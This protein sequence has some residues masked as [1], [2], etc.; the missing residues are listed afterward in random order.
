MLSHTGTAAADTRPMVKV[1]TRGAERHASRQWVQKP[2]LA[3]LVQ[4]A[5]FLTPIGLGWVTV[6]LTGAAYVRPDGWIGTGLWIVQAFAVCGVVVHLAARAAERIAPLTALLNLNL[7]FPDNA[8]SRFRTALRAGTV[9]KIA[10]DELVL[11]SDQQEAAE[12]AIELVGRLTKHERL[13]R[14]HT[15]RVRAYAEVIGA[16]LDLPKEDLEMLRW[17]VLL[18][19]IGKLTV[20]AHILSKNGRPTDAEWEIL[21]THPAAAVEILEPLRDWLGEWIGAASEH[22]ER[23]DGDGYPNGLAGREISL[24]GRITAVADAFDVITSKRSYKE[25]ISDEAARQELVSCSGGQFDP[26][27]VRAFLQA[28]VRK[29]RTL[30]LFSWILELQS[31][32]SAI[33][34][35][36]SAPAIVAST[37]VI[38]L[39]AVT[40]GVT[41]EPPATIAFV[42]TTNTLEASE[43]PSTT[44]IGPPASTSVPSS[45]ATT[46]SPSTTS[47]TTTPNDQ[48]TTTTTRQP[49]TTTTATATAEAISTTAQ[50]TT[51]ATSTTTTT[52]PPAGSWAMNDTGGGN[53]TAN[54]SVRVLSNDILPAEFDYLSLSIAVQ[55]DHGTTTI[56][57]NS[58]SPALTYVKFRADSGFVG[59][60]S[61][62]YEIC[63]LAGDCATATVTMTIISN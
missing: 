5:L 26:K 54:I 2:L 38:G 61:F 11:S 34:Y 48:T 42:E 15:E 56:F 29:P 4:L 32:R 39:A 20:P 37:A 3:K 28:G 36:G 45:T 57:Y 47:T 59:T 33:S 31:I 52:V 55:S 58:G 1:P 51:T 6:R 22:H 49:T 12:Q 40:S 50:T 19:D 16:E 8:P 63:D 17:G 14:G 7:V 30:G 53:K 27:V 10:S 41:P 9:R 23:F 62:V 44:T 25:R 18:H 24:A 43:E 60:T 35:A 13:T 21:K 46:G